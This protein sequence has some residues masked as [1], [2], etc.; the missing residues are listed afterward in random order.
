MRLPNVAERIQETRKSQGLT[1]AALAA[2]MG[3]TRSQVTLWETSGR[4]PSP[5]SLKRIAMALGVDVEWLAT[6]N[7]MPKALSAST[8]AIDPQLFQMVIEAVHAA[9]RKRKLNANS[10]RFT[11]V[12]VTVYT[13]SIILWINSAHRDTEQFRAYLAGAT[14]L[15][16]GA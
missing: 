1:Q 7:G 14:D 11:Q 10:Q 5:T 6:G 15:A 8:G 4:N 9:F 3:V 2:R 12:V 13:A 16:L